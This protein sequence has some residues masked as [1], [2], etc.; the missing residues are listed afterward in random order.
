MRSRSAIFAVL[1]L[2]STAWAEEIDKAKLQG[3][4][5]L[6]NITLMVDSDSDGFTLSASKPHPYPRK[7]IAEVRQSLKGDAS[8]AAL[9][10]ELG[11]I[12]FED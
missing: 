11:F 4:L 1:V 5:R 7:R 12:Q 8:D 2:A 3:T 9:F 6:P 10:S